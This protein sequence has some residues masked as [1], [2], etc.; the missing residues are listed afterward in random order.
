MGYTVDATEKSFEDIAVTSS[1]ADY[2]T[3][4]Q[5]NENVIKTGCT[6]CFQ[7]WIIMNISYTCLRILK[8]YIFC[9]LSITPSC[10]SDIG[11]LLRKSP[12]NQLFFNQ[13]PFKGNNKAN[14]KVLHYWSFL[15]SVSVSWSLQCGQC[16]HDNYNLDSN[17]SPV[18]C[19]IYTCPLLCGYFVTCQCHKTSSC[20]R[21]P[22]S[23]I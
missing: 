4:C 6:G 19:R 16:T 3:G 15:E 13:W 9:R 11:Y 23:H 10:G 8:Q 2:H 22:A 20:C 7:N 14:F 18:S 21:R 1:V 17:T 12:V 5:R